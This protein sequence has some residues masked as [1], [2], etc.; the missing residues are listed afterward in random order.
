MMDTSV[1]CLYLCF[2][3]P[4]WYQHAMYQFILFKTYWAD[5]VLFTKLFVT[6]V[7]GIGLYFYLVNIRQA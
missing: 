4:H 2:S 3:Y 1:H 7:T 6:V 5:D